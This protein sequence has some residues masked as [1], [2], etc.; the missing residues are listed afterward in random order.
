M[1]GPDPRIEPNKPQEFNSKK[2]S[3]D[4]DARIMRLFATDCSHFFNLFGR[5]S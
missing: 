2:Y 4:S 1:T 3:S 5:L